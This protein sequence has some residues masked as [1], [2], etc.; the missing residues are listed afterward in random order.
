MKN[1]EK[2]IKE[3]FNTFKNSV[4]ELIERGDTKDLKC[5]MEAFEAKKYEILS[6]D[7]EQLKR[8]A[9]NPPQGID[10]TKKLVEIALKEHHDKALAKYVIKS[11]L[12]RAEDSYDYYR[13]AVVVG[14]LLDDRGWTKKLFGIALDKDKDLNHFFRELKDLNDNITIYEVLEL[15]ENKIRKPENKL[16]LAKFLVEKLNDTNRATE[17]ISSIFASDKKISGGE[18][19][20]IIEFASKQLDDQT[21]THEMIDRAISRFES[22]CDSLWIAEFLL[23]DLQL[24]DESIKVIKAALQVAT[25]KSDL[26]DIARF[27]RSKLE[28]PEWADEVSRKAHKL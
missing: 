10:E 9:D 21:F 1:S 17:I 5:L 12:S 16:M 2:N 24:K 14:N 18:L 7:K 3:I 26:F 15:V 19:E 23:D 25:D 13:A 11:A 6:N 28:Q 4:E 22:P 27:I 20:R 8:D